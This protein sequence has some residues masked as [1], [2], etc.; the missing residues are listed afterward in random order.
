M[1]LIILAR[2]ENI[3]MANLKKSLDYFAFSVD[4]FADRKIR[5]LQNVFAEKG[6]IIYIFIL[7]EIYRNDGYFLVWD[8]EYPED[9]AGA[10]FG[11]DSKS[12]LVSEVVSHCVNK[13]RLFDKELFDSQMILTSRGIQRR[14]LASKEGIYKKSLDLLKL[15]PKFRLIGDDLEFSETSANI[16]DNRRKSEN[17]ANIGDNRREIKEIKERNEIEE[18]KNNSPLS[19]QGETE[20]SFSFDVP[21]SLNFPQFLAAWKDWEKY[22]REKRQ[23]LKPTT[24]KKQLDFLASLGPER[25]VKSINQSIMQGWTGLFEPKE[26]TALQQTRPTETVSISRQ[27]IIQEF[28]NGK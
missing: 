2:H 25:A 1:S 9:I 19:P 21:E 7:T 3:K 23:T 13:F 27:K 6:L 28:L 22:R 17:S 15:I 16:G 10:L 20:N 14:Y 11:D 24:V 26:E 4:F 5:R 8:S 12:N 18:N